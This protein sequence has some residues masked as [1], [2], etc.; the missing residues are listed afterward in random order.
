ML[1]QATDT[2]DPAIASDG[3]AEPSLTSRVRTRLEQ[4]ILSGEVRAGDHINENALAAEFAVSRA[5]IREATRALAEAGLVTVIRN[6]GA[7]VREVSLEDV[8]H[9]Y[10][11][12][13]GLARV[14][15]RLAALRASEA[16][17]DALRSLWQR[18]EEAR[19]DRDSDRYYEVNRSFHATIMEITANPR[20]ID[21][22]ETTEAEVFLFLRRGVTGSARL[23]VSNRQHKQVVD[24]IAAGDELAAARAFENH[25]IA[26]KQRMLDTLGWRTGR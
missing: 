13:A 4:M 1:E 20:L 17:V 7:F 2:L 14:A 8:L 24:A 26:G 22:H 23:D 5:P 18:M 12:R 16:Q 25:V 11:V 9:V 21:F 3:D 6:R 10:D 19:I 15:G